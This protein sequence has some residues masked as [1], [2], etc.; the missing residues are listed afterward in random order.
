V[1]VYVSLLLVKPSLGPV[2]DVIFLRTLQV[3]KPLLYYNPGGLYGYGDVANLGRFTILAGME[4]NLSGFFFKSPSAFWYF[5]FQAFQYVLLMA[6]LIVFLSRFTTNKF[7]IYGIPILL[8]LFPGTTIAFFRTHIGDRSVIF[9]YIIFLYF[10]FLY[11]EKGKLWHLVTGVVSANMAIHYKETAFIALAAFAFFHLI[12]SRKKS[13][14]G[15]KIFDGLVILSSL[16]FLFL[17]YFI[18]FRH[19][20]PQAVLY[21]AN[22][23][24]PLLVFIKNF[25][26]YG[27][28]TDPIM[29][30]ALLPFTGWRIYKALRKQLE[31]HPIYDSMLIAASMHVLGFFVLRIFSP[32]F[33][34]PAYVFALPPLIY[35][36]SRREQRT[37][38]WKGVAAVCGL[39]LFLNVLPAGIHYITYHKYLYLNFNKTVDFLIQDI[40]SRYPR[41][42]ANIFFDAL[43]YQAGASVH[44][45]IFSEFLQYKGLT[46]NR[47]DFKSEVKFGD[48]DAWFL[49]I[50]DFNLPFTVFKNSEF[51]K[52]ESGDYLIITPYSTTK[53]ITKTYIQSLNRDYDLV[54]KTE[55]PLEIPDFNLKTLAKYILSKRLSQSQKS[56]K[57]IMINENLIQRPDY[58]VFIRK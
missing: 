37:F 40:N 21:N 36:F 14:L 3:G 47:F 54:F 27:F 28:F 4:Y 31:L 26:N 39:A 8:S 1:A 20:P 22:P 16:V 33:L 2:D 12:L 48:M 45:L 42:R 30:L 19:L 29:I 52:T 46:G 51:Y 49:N 44:Y 13:K 10:Y 11:L 50:K 56:E 53:N 58:Y 38:F 23:F 41:Q 17:Y 43:D 9:Y 5:L 6:I 57:G 24:N 18:A 35:F 25:L 55:S 34:M 15:V 7:L 32:S